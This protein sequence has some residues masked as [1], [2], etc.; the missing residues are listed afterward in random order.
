MGAPLTFLTGHQTIV[1][2]RVSAIVSF[3][4]ELVDPDKVCG[5]S[6]ESVGEC[7]QEDGCLC[8]DPDVCLAGIVHTGMEASGD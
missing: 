5:C 2:D 8:E 3:K 7:M 6:V 1:A 4:E